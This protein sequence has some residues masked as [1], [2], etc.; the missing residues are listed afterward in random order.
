MKEESCLGILRHMR[1]STAIRSDNIRF[2]L[3][4]KKTP[5]R[6]KDYLLKNLNKY[7]NLPEDIVFVDKNELND[8]CNDD[9][10]LVFTEHI[11]SWRHPRAGIAWRWK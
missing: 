7:I 6:S 8:L 9:N 1:S 4:I 2:K 5:F 10:N 3:R 11:G